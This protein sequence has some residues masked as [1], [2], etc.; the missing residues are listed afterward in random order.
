MSAKKLFFK[1]VSAP[2][3][4]A[5]FTLK[6]FSCGFLLVVYEEDVFCSCCLLCVAFSFF[7]VEKQGVSV[8]FIAFKRP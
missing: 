2:V 4:E 5:I 7:C 6:R 1:F 8:V 3:P